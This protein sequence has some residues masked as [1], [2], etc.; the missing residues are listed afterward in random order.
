[1]QVD[2]K[3]SDDNGNFKLKH[4][5]ENYGYDLEAAVSK[6]PIKELGRDDYKESL[7]DSLKKG[8]VQSVTFQVDGKEQK[9]FIEANPQFK[10]VNVYDSDMQRLGSRESKSEKQAEGAGQD[11][12]RA[13][14]TEVKNAE[15][16]GDAPKADAKKKRG[17]KV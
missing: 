10:T 1:M 17:Q 9:H 6:H 2:F 4:Y 14:K 5:H 7:M 12:K 3:N 13:A 8:N 15:A 16:V 11:N